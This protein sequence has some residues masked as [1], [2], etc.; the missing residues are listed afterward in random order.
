MENSDDHCSVSPDRARGRVGII[1]LVPPAHQL[2]YQENI[3]SWSWPCGQALG[4]TNSTIQTPF[5]YGEQNIKIGV[6]DSI[7]DAPLDISGGESDLSIDQKIFAENQS[8]GKAP[9]I[10]LA[11]VTMLGRNAND[12][13]ISI[14]VGLEDLKGAYL[15]QKLYNATHTIKIKLVIGN[16]GTSTDY[17][18]SIPQIINRLALLAKQDQTFRGIIGLP[19]SSQTLALVDARKTLGFEDV[20]PIISSSS[21]SENLEKVPNFYHIPPSDHVQA[22]VLYDFIAQQ[23][24]PAIGLQH[25]PTKKTTVTLGILQ[26]AG[27]NYSLSLASSLT[28]ISSEHSACA[29]YSNESGNIQIVARNPVSYDFTQTNFQNQANFQ[30]QLRQLISQNDLLF[31]SGYAYNLPVIE[32]TLANMPI[33]KKVYIVGGDGSFASL[34]RENQYTTLFSTML[35]TPLQVNDPFAQAYIRTFGRDK[36]ATATDNNILVPP[37]AIQAYE[38]VEAFAN[39]LPQQGGVPSQKDFDAA[40]TNQQ[41]TGIN[42]DF[43]HF[44]RANTNGSPQKDQV[45]HLIGLCL[46]CA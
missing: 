19:F 8:I 22:C 2:C 4:Y 42:N 43:I 35:V 45:T 37:H 5:N 10:T 40:L 33:K 41:F 3:L 32:Q 23:L 31:Y 26:Q 38:A 24:A 28:A 16:I 34:G 11:V 46:S 20:L 44:D 13:T 18:E 1:R 21:T 6:I 9:Y 29:D 17:Q 30:Q 12:N 25:D 39:V 36:V 14:N 27:D 7:G 15:Y